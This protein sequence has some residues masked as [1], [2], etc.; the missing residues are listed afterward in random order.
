MASVKA[1]CKS[2]RGTGLYSGMAEPKGIAVVC[3]RCEG[4]GC[5]EINYVPFE[6][7]QR[8]SDVEV[9][10]LSAGTTIALGCGPAGGAVTYEQFLAGKMPEA[11]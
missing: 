1:E 5:R 6:R 3:L 4:S 9:V 2:C 10:R 11:Q 7:R 8:R